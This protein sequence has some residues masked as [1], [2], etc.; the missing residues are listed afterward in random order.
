MEP[1]RDL[2]TRLVYERIGEYRRLL[3]E[4]WRCLAATYC[5]RSIAHLRMGNRGIR[6]SASSV[7]PAS[8]P[9]RWLALLLALG[10]SAQ[11]AALVGGQPDTDADYSYAVFFK[12]DGQ[13]RC[14][15][16]KIGPRAFLT[17]A[18][19]VV[20]IS[21]GGL[22][23]AFEPGGTILLTN[24][25]EPKGDSDYRSLTVEA[26]R[27]PPAFEAALHRLHEYQEEQIAGYRWR[28]SGENLE[29]RIRRVQA[30]SRISDRF[31]DAAIVR[32]RLET[33]EIP[34]A[35]FDLKPLAAGAQ[36]VLVG[37]GCERASDLMRRDRATLPVRR[38]WGETRVIRVD[39]VNFYTFAA[40]LRPGTPVLC[41]GDSG[42][43]VVSGGRVVGVHGTVWG[44]HPMTDTARSNMSVNLAAIA[45]WDAWPKLNTASSR[46]AASRRPHGHRKR[47]ASPGK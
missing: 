41:P 4:V 26:T 1:K 45:D 42:G 11:A 6:Q 28:Y 21:K 23:Q 8:W 19:C 2:L 33:P 43:P 3:A 22:V 13:R 44:L 34:V 29:R 38:T 9:M 24:R 25:A 16:T 47:G 15:A 17:A 40:E 32:L 36:A 39:K 10:L 18:H 46:G 12:V 30:D 31:P 5:C 7:E 35:P 27:L 37:Y 14:T 20:D